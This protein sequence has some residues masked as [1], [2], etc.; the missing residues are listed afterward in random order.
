MVLV[1]VSGL[2][3]CLYVDLISVSTADVTKGLS[4][5]V[6]ACCG[7]TAYNPLNEICCN[8]TVLTKPVAFAQCCGSGE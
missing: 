2:D 8:S 1:S 5:M 4:E 6:S 3:L 7:L